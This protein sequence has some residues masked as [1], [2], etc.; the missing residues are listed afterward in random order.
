MVCFQ[1]K[2]PNLDTFWRA[3][4]C[5]FFIYFMAVWNI[6]WRFCHSLWPFG[7]FCV[8]LVHF[9]GLGSMYQEKSGN[10]GVYVLSRSVSVDLIQYR[11][12]APTTATTSTQKN[13]TVNIFRNIRWHLA[14]RRFNSR[15]FDS[16]QFDLTLVLTWPAKKTFDHFTGWRFI[17]RH[18]GQL[19]IRLFILFRRPKKPGEAAFLY[20]FSVRCWL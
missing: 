12:A 1:T 16:C 18:R 5:K 19:N 3:L 20:S 17:D 14:A 4:D 8:H 10:P 2:N 11:K 7:R 6:S 13:K 9:S 15:H